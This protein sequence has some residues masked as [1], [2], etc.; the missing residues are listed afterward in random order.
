MKKKCLFLSTEVNPVDFCQTKQLPFKEITVFNY[1]RQMLFWS[2]MAGFQ[3][4]IIFL[5]AEK[6]HI[7]KM[8]S[9]SYAILHEIMP[10]K[11]KCAQKVAC[12]SAWRHVPVWGVRKI[13]PQSG[14]VRLAW[15]TYQSAGPNWSRRVLRPQV[16]TA[17]SS[18]LRRWSLESSEGWS[19]SGTHGENDLS[20][21]SAQSHKFMGK[22]RC[23]KSA[24]KRLCQENQ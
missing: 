5:Q 4:F 24:Q 13:T 15:R 2:Q 9:G 14:A 21:L 16:H 12:G 19:L 10:W 22:H 3:V 23:D 6:F 20:F 8:R 7:K 18:Y 17:S 1:I 11:W